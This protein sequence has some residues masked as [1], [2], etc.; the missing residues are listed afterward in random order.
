MRKHWFVRW[1]ALASL[2]LAGT[3][4]ANASDGGSLGPPPGPPPE[5]LEAC[6]R[7]QEGAC[8]FTHNG[9]QLSGT[10]R[11]GPQGEPAACLPDRPPPGRCGPPQEALQACAGLQEGASCSFSLGGRAL[12]GTCRTGPDGS[13]MACAPSQPPPQH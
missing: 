6:S 8:S 12:S 3:E 2:A 13:T 1:A 11:T 7:L 9:N 10:C 5:A 4:K